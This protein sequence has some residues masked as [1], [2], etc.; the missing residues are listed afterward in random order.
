MYQ[1]N[2]LARIAQAIH[3]TPDQAEL[4]ID[5][6]C[7]IF[8]WLKGRDYSYDKVCTMILEAAAATPPAD[9]DIEFIH[10]WLKANKV[11]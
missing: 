8:N 3:Q 11:P 2:Q 10:F 4:T 7:Y 6:F 1:E 9:P 5:T